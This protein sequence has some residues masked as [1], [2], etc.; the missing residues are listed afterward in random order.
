MN[1][2][3]TIRSGY[4]IVIGNIPLALEDTKHNGVLVGIDNDV[5]CDWNTYE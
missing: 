3:L 1:Q 5:L 4:L 2:T